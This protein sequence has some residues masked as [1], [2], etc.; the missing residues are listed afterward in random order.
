MNNINNAFKYLTGRNGI[1]NLNV[2]LIKIYFLILILN[3]FLKLYVFGILEL[4]LFILIIFRIFSK[5]V[6]KR[7]KEN[8]IFIDV[9]N[10]IIKPFKKKNYNDDSYVYKKCHK[11]RKTLRLPIPFKKGIKKVKCPKCEHMNKFLVLKEEKIEIIKN[12]RMKKN[13]KVI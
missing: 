4:V 10:K 11:C 1:D 2:F 12:G 6:N 13:D 8:K 7:E 3:I 5:N 9:V